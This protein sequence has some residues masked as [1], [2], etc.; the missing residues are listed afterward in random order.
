[1]SKGEHLYFLLHD[2]MLHALHLFVLPSLADSICLPTRQCAHGL[3]SKS[4]AEGSVCRV[5]RGGRR[6]QRLW[7]HISP[8]SSTKTAASTLEW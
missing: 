8:T 5:K 1:M 4:H 6:A 2:R 7:L 3:H